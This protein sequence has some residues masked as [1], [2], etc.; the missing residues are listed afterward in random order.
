[1]LEM[2]GMHKLSLENREAC[3]IAV[4]FVEAAGYSAQPRCAIGSRR[5]V[6]M[7]EKQSGDFPLLAILLSLAKA[8]RFLTY[9]R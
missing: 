5:I 9:E 7:G 4:E 2:V 6:R 8:L 3:Q 1:M